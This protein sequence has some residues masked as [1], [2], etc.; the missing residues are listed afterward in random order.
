LAHFALT[1]FGS[2][3]DLHPYIA[4]GLGL[5]ERG[6]T[7][8]IAT[9]E[10]YRNKV[11]GEGLGFRAIRPDAQWIKDDAAVM[12]QA[13][14]PRTGSEY[15]LRTLFLPWVEQS[16]EDLL[17]L[18]READLL[19]GHPIAFATPLVAEKL[20]KPWVS[21]ILQ[22]SLLLSAWDPPA[23]SGIPELDWFLGYGPGLWKFFF[24][25]ARLVARRWGAPINRFRRQLGLREVRNPILDDMFSPHGNQAWFSRLMAQPQPDWPG[26][27][28]VTG[29]PFYDKLEPGGGMA[30]EL[31]AFLDSG[32]P[33]VVFT[34]GSSAVFDAGGFYRE[35]LEAVR[36]VGCR[37]VLLI[38]QDP[39][40]VPAGPVPES[41]FLAEYAPY[42]E[43]LPR[44]AATVHQGG[45]GTTAQALLS[46]RPMIVVPWS[47]DQPDNARRAVRLGV[48]R[49]IPRHQYCGK[50]VA[51]EVRSLLGNESYRRR[52]EEAAVE[53]SQ[54]DGV[55]SACD[56]LE[57]RLAASRANS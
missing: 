38:G 55:R 47:H 26:H 2:L 30:A 39:R 52:A 10:S 45:S 7:V 27:M 22:P 6:H 3:G 8:T 56:A 12:R 53:L 28:D 32:A 48:A 41:V 19:V 25:F 37:A 35:S 49:T 36:A 34:L 51:A 18:A 46:G 44:A 11:E 9:S 23:V 31:E 14:H 43:L 29:Y 5:R 17:P 13:F 57:A 15:I 21:V 33:P 16:Y 24:D 54:E 40:N 42:S 1:T 20:G 50:R 4:V